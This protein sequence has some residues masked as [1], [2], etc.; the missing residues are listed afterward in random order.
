MKLKIQKLFTIAAVCLIFAACGYAAGKDGSDNL[1][2]AKAFDETRL[3]KSFEMGNSL[4]TAKIVSVYSLSGE[5]HKRKIDYFYYTAEIKPIIAGDMVEK[6]F[7]L[8]VE[9]TVGSYTGSLLKPGRTYAIFASKDSPNGF[10]WADKD[11]FVELTKENT[12]SVQTMAEKVYAKTEI[13]KFRQ[14]K[15]EKQVTLPELEQEVAAACEQFKTNPENRAKF[16]QAIYDSKLG[17]R[18]H[19]N[20]EQKRMTYSKP[21]MVLSRDQLVALL[22]EP[23]IKLGWTYKWYCGQEEVPGL[24]GQVGVLSVVF[25]KDYNDTV[26]AY[27]REDKLKWVK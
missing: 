4:V 24:T 20:E 7:E 1:P 17:S 18:K 27:T 12:K 26:L 10:Y 3:A 2:K 6:D 23:T 11:D 19:M 9:L 14:I 16:G 21:E 22:G 15:S 25:D 13:F 5:K 8:P